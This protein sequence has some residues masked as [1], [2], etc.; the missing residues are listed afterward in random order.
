MRRALRI[1][2][3]GARLA[4]WYAAAATATLACLFVVGYFLLQGYLIHG[5]DLL[6]QS[7]FEQ[8]RARLGKDYRGLTPAVID[9]RIRDTTNYASVLFYID[10]HRPR[11][12]T[13]F[14]SQNLKGHSIPD[15]KGERRYEIRWGQFGLLRVG[16]F[17]LPPFDVIVATP[18]T[19]V[20]GVMEGYASVCAALLALMLGMSI[21]IGYGLSRLALRPV[22]LIR[23][24]ANRIG[25]D[26]LGERI[27]VPAT[28]DEIADLVTLLNAMFDRLENS[29]TNVRRF[30][31]DASHELKTPLSLARL[32][33]EKL[34]ATNAL[35]ADSEEEGAA[36]LEELSRMTS[37][38][39]ELLFL[40]RA[41]ARSI[42]FA[43]APHEPAAVLA[44]FT[45]DALVLAEHRGL[46]FAAAHS[47]EGLAVCEPR[48]LRRVLLNLMSNAVNASPPGGRIQLTSRIDHERWRVSIEDEGAGVPPAQRAHL[49]DRFVRL[50]PSPGT[51]SEGTGLGLAICRGIIELHRGR[52]Y[53]E[54]G[55]GGRGLRA[56]FEI[57]AM[58]AGG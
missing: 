1:R 11:H 16:E 9:Q 52:I 31:A 25:S 39:D 33:A 53:V 55:S 7:E 23:E 29:F 17:R 21:A 28:K 27:P 54:D 13:I 43:L 12:G 49:F 6:N 56:V 40:S 48:W 24:T 10:I 30:A 58:A 26:N 2:S 20:D 57:P 3:I 34:L 45:A 36:L 15:V 19:Q 22:R 50:R 4:L 38:I 51:D 46:R 47:G 18:A 32:H 42:T 35:T 8:I 41:E 44:S 14:Y 5:L 37:T